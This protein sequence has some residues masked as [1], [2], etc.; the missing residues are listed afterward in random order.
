MPLLLES[1]PDRVA[2]FSV[3]SG[4]VGSV[5]LM[6]LHVSFVACMRATSSFVCSSPAKTCMRQNKRTINTS[7]STKS[8]K[9]G[10]LIH[11]QTARKNSFIFRDCTISDTTDLQSLSPLHTKDRPL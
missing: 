6:S 3:G 8:T 2:L 7:A 4:S 11:R 10:H 5:P 1:T 9:S